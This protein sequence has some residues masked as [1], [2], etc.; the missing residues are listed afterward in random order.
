MM[1]LGKR[2][3][4]QVET[5]V[6]DLDN[7][8]YPHH[9]NLWQQVDARIRDFVAEWLKVSPEEAFRIQKDYYKRYGTTMRG[10]MTEHGVHA[11]DYLA[12]VHAIDHSP[13]LPNPAMGDAIQRLPGR[14]LILTNGSVAHAGKVLERLGI[15]HHFEAV[16]DIIAAE[17]EPKPAPQT[18]RRFL[19]RHGVD[20]ARAAM[21]EDL[22]RN[23]TVPHQLG[24]TTVLVVPD[25]S[26]EVVREDWE[27][28]GRDAAHVDHVTDDLTGFLK[29]LS[30]AK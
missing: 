20:P 9:L 11:D 19:D 18:Y 8:L 24:M 16:F 5:W 4:D 17:L 15:G 28:E 2:G 12:Y 13:L 25:G 23:L 3:F 30:A 1:Q 6:F 29:T 14:K 22:A 27:L 21:F 26:Q 10:M 7:T